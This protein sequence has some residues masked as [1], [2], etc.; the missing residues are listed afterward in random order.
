MLKNNKKKQVNN[1]QRAEEQK[2]EDD[3]TL[4]IY[5]RKEKKVVLLR[6]R[7]KKKEAGVQYWTEKKE[8]YTHA[9]RTS[10]AI[11]RNSAAHYKS[12]RRIG[13]CDSSVSLNK[14]EQ[15]Q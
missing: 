14:S 11:N 4:V 1:I 10:K 9:Q 15:T 6:R 13:S 8:I 3:S 5:W 2:T 7:K 12:A